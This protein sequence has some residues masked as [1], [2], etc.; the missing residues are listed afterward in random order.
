MVEQLNNQ[1]KIEDIAYNALERARQVLQ[2]TIA[3]REEKYGYDHGIIDKQL[4]Q[5]IAGTVAEMTV[6]NNTVLVVDTADDSQEYD[7]L[8]GD[9]NRVES[10]RMALFAIFVGIREGIRAINQGPSE[11]PSP[12]S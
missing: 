10:S 6:L 5:R 12:T 11:I 4:L 9:L 1:E 7:L 8:I 3:S 2:Q